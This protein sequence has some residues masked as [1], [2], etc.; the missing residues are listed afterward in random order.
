MNKKYNTVSEEDNQLTFLGPNDGKY[1]EEASNNKSVT[2]IPLVKEDLLRDMQYAEYS[3]VIELE[4]LHSQI[5]N[6]HNIWPDH[7]IRFEITQD[8]KTDIRDK[9]RELYKLRDQ[10]TKLETDL[11]SKSR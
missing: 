9:E 11:V 10:I 5:E 6:A 8:I 4:R 3:L 1:P 7:Q 2:E